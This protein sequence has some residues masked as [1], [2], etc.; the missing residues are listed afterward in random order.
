MFITEVVV[1]GGVILDYLMLSCFYFFI[2]P[3]YVY[4]NTRNTSEYDA[5]Q[6]NT[7]ANYVTTSMLKHIIQSTRL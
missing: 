1:K 7:T 4:E 5:V 3:I 2:L 6:Y